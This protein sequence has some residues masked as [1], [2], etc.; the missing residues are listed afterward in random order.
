MLALHKGRPH[1]FSLKEMLE[2]F[3]DHRVDVIQRRTRYLKRKA[4]DR[5]HIVEGLLIAIA[6]IDEVV[7]VIK[8]SE[9]PKVAKAELEARFVLSERQ[10]EAILA[11]RLSRLTGLEVEK[12]QDEKE[13]LEGAIARYKL[14]L[15]DVGEVHKLII[16]ELE[17]LKVRFPDG[18]RTEIS[19]EE[20]EIQ[21]EAL[22]P[23]EKVLVT[24][25]HRGYIKRLPVDTYRSQ[26]RGGKGIMGAE[27]KDDDFIERMILA[28]THDYFLVF[29]NWG[30][31]HWLKVW[32][33]PELGRNSL[34]RFI[35]NILPLR[36]DDG[37]GGRGKERITSI[38]PVS[39]F[40]EDRYLVTVSRQGMVKKSSL[41]LYSRPKRGGIIGVGMKP[42][43]TLVRAILAEV[44]QDLLVS[45][46]QGQTIRF[47][48]S[49]AR[50]MG[51]SAAGVIAVKFK[52]AGD[53]VVDA[54]VADDDAMLL[55]VCANGYG[56]RV[57][58]GDYPRKN[59]GGMG[60]V[61]I[62]GLDRN[63][64]VVIARVNRDG[65]HLILI[66]QSGK[67]VRIPSNQV[68]CI[69][70][71]GKGVRVMTMG[72]GDEVVAGVLLDAD[73]ESSELAASEAPE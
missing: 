57:Q 18:R 45:T 48:E 51:R 49:D 26:G 67:V 38:I 32:R 31:A 16:A 20:E 22:I 39:S 9:S 14:I 36:A 11:M 42:G 33:I 29:T 4:E 71:G 41:S 2:A 65:D 54:A 3:R 47:R 7:Q 30:W 8:A 35:E 64:D 72:A 53:H 46:S 24:L 73:E 69:G 66:S 37:E 63:G 1:T 60:V 12:L 15:S 17:D 58:I 61:N 34:G 10:S 13:E 59:R 44:G 62:R 23:C 21:D 55:T 25:T 68:R 40:D 56:Q 5:L 43:D 70:R 50:S 27:T 6:S 28:E 19:E 52:T